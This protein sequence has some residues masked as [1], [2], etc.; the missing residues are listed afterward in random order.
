MAVKTIEA[1][2]ADEGLTVLGWRELPTDYSR[3]WARRRRST[4]PAFRQIFVTG[5]GR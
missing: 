1:I 5:P 4:M 2:A 3:W